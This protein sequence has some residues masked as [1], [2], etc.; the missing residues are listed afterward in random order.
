MRKRK[1]W[2]TED[3]SGKSDFEFNVTTQWKKAIDNKRVVEVYE[4]FECESDQIE[5]QLIRFKFV[6]EFNRSEFE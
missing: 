6:F 4:L 2:K 1:K 5:S 3:N